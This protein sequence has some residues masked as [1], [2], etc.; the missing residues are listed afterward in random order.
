MF[1]KIQL[2]GFYTLLRR[3]LRRVV[4]LW[5]QTLVPSV[6]TAALYFFIF[7]HVI[8]NAIG[9][10]KGISYF[11]F[12]L[13]GLIMMGVINNAYNGVVAS[14]FMAKFARF[15]EEILVSPLNKLWLILGYTL[16]GVT[17]AF[18]V[19]ALVL[20]TASF[21]EPIHLAHAFFT[22]SVLLLAAFL[23][24]LLGFINALFAKTWDDINLIPTFILTPLIYLGGVFYSVDHLPPFWQHL[25]W[26]NP[27]YYIIDA[28]RYGFYGF[29][30][31]PPTVAL[32]GLASL[33][34]LALIA[35]VVLVKRGK[36]FTT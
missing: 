2:T 30:I 7:G 26:L 24:A 3:E 16:A 6:I 1:N 34:F 32:L 12:I 10:L 27:I 5:K 13:P 25:I 20:I 29:S 23:F 28:C 9:E 33:T 22:I 36:G 31:L 35:T 17:R 14:L 18:C 4:R 21:F 8:G 15:I 19:G 11:N